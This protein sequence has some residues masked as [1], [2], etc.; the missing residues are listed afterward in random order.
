MHQA[1]ALPARVSLSGRDSW[2]LGVC[3]KTYIIQNS[4]KTTSS[5]RIL[6]PVYSLSRCILEESFISG[7][8]KGQKLCWIFTSLTLF[9]NKPDV[10]H[11]FPPVLCQSSTSNLSGY[12]SLTLTSSSGQPSALS[13][14]R[15]K[16]R[17]HSRHS[18]TSRITGSKI[19]RT[20]LWSLLGSASSTPHKDWLWHTF[21]RSKQHLATVIL[22]QLQ[23]P[24]FNAKN[25]F[26]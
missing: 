22:L 24:S 9:I 16:T 20:R 11:K 5:G 15:K 21:L 18:K 19:N 2:R 25:V 10:L 14:C 12:E 3:P 17:F 7:S 26:K 6:C 4:W 8:V 23:E 1:V 13:V